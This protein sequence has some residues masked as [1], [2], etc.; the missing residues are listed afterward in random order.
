MI[1]MIET[2]AERQHIEVLTSNGDWQTAY[3]RRGQFVDA[4]GL[5]LDP[6]KIARWRPVE[7]SA[8]RQDS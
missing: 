4:Y 1:D 6:Q 2:P 5:F 8:N 3:F 7:Q